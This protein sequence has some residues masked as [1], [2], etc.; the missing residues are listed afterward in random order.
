LDGQSV[1]TIVDHVLLQVALATVNG[2]AIQRS[3]FTDVTVTFTGLAALPANPA[4]AFR[5]T[6]TAPDG[7]TADVVLTVDLSPSTAT[8][9]IARLT[10]GGPVAEL[11]SLSD[12]RYRLTAFSAQ[13]SR[14]GQ[15]LDG[16]ANG[17]QGRRLHD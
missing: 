12:G 3:R 5:L 2:G 14:A 7:S 13:A 11:G 15:P 17:T 9:T 8:Q 10:F 4:D 1:G 6:R 16:D